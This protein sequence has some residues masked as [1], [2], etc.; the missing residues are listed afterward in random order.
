MGGREVYRHHTNL[1]GA[2]QGV[3]ATPTIAPKTAYQATLCDINRDSTQKKIIPNGRSS[4]GLSYAG[5][6]LS[7]HSGSSLANMSLDHRYGVQPGSRS[8]LLPWNPDFMRFW[9]HTNN[10][11]SGLT[12][13]VPTGSTRQH[14]SLDRYEQCNV[15]HSVRACC[16]F[17]LQSKN[18]ITL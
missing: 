8:S 2:G 12:E 10:S 6:V 7:S 5:T 18:W 15:N 4:G 16:W 3:T 1:H 13:S 11:A 14:F 9:T 17:H